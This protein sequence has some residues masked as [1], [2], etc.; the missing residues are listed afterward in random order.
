M[1]LITEDHLEQQCLEWFKE[2][3]YAYAFAPDLAPDGTSP[4]RTDFRQVIL[5]GRLRSALKRLNP[6]VPASTIESAVLQLA[7]PNVPG[8]LA[9]NRNFHRWM[10]Q[11][12]PI[13]YMDGNQQVGIRLKVIGFDD[14]ASNDWLVVNQLAIQG[15]KHNRRPDVVVY[16][17][18]LPLAVIELKNPADQKADI[19]AGFNQLQTYKQDIPDLFTPNVLLV[20]SDGI[21][22]RLG[23]LSADKER[24]QRW[25][26]IEGENHLDPLGNHRDLETLV[27]G[28]FDQGRLLEFVRR[29][30]LFEE[31]GQIIKKI[32]AY[33]QFHAVRAAVESVVEA[34]RPDGDK[35]GGV[36]W[37]TQGAGKSIE[38]AC[39]AGKLLTDPRLENPTLVMVTDRQDLDG[40]LFG[41]FAGAGDLLGESPKQAESRQELRELLGNRPSGG[42]I[43]TTIQ[44]F[45]TEPDEDKFP[46]LTE[47]HNIVVICDEAHR[48]QYGFKGRF[49]T[50]TGEIKYGLAKALRDA[51][52][53]ATFLAF[54]GT[55]ISQDDRDTQAV[56][57]H[58]VSVYDI[59]QAVEDGATVPI[60]YESR[61]AKLALKDPL[62]PQLDAAVDAL[63]A[64]EAEGFPE[65][66]DDIPAAER[67]KSRW[68]A[69]EAL[70]GAEPRLKQVAADLI[71]HFEQRSR[72]QPG[73][74]MVVAMSRDICA[75]LYA[76]IVALR[77]DW[78]DDDP[79]KGAIKVVMTAS[80]SD[81]QYLQPHHTT[82]Q[83][84]KDLE[85]RFKD[86]TDP[87]KI[88][89]V[90]DM[91]LTGFDAPCLATMYVD[92]PMKGAN[93][94]QAIARVNRVFK[95]KPGGLVVDYIG[96]AP[97]LKEALATYT[98]SKGKG[99][100]TI[101]T[102]EAL[103]ILKEKLQVARD[104]L[105]PIDWSGFKDSKT[106]MALL[107]DCV[108]HVLGLPDGKKRY[109]DTVLAITKAFALCGTLDEAM[110]LTDEVAFLQAIRAP[111]IKG[112]GVDGD[113]SDPKNV[114]FELRQLLSESLV[115]DGITDIFKV[116]GLQKPDLSILSDQFLAE[117]SK[118]PQKNLAVELLQRL[119]REEVQTRFKTNVVKQKRFSELLQASLNKYANRS[120]E[121]AQV[122]EELIAMAKQF[123]DEA[124]KVEAMGLSVAEVAFYD[125]LANNQSAHDLMGD[126]VLM[127]MARELAEKLRGNLSI[128]WQY[129]ENVRARLRTMIKA[130]LKRYKYPPDQEAAAIDLVL[131]QTEMISEE[132]AREDLGNKIQAVVAD[133]LGKQF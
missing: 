132:W 61:L 21:Q 111:I 71:A 66:V 106:A 50:K 30:C 104:L 16:V 29:F 101:D 92:K 37:H 5:T 97:Q 54:T 64:D 126:E 133:A 115:A 114:D 63:F 32:A 68:A 49:D 15:T 1:A 27:R 22:A 78:H 85:K 77:P 9:S 52:P 76:A 17:N 74:A 121:A 34:S 25:R 35:K 127:K 102:S 58:Y 116:A 48:T 38:M 33:H 96:I 12:L 3:G 36:V 11:G 67:A 43:F 109:C 55:P 39:L 56:F 73:K 91:W 65:G 80:A 2:L 60:F 31:D 99:A 105:H 57:G 108:G 122:I 103:R 119:L 95:D 8:L 23:S 107:P 118:I 10:T 86:P 70:V 59:Q 18:G 79:K 40:Q 117:I 13:T 72:T 7:N 124:E 47:R 19:W 89:I 28:I 94:A 6:G 20:I 120:I 93:L 131:Q 41:V 83:Q 24:F 75:R 81:E 123:R 53:Q 46:A 82:K 4:E 130:L 90:R 88:V 98:A 69:L 112:D 87:L 14:P 51:L 125:A 42:I 26:T 110:A 62:L 128:D 84:K 113:G 100:P 129:K 44:K 45:A